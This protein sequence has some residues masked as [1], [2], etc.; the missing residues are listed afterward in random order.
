MFSCMS[1]IALGVASAYAQSGPVLDTSLRRFEVGGQIADI[2]TGCIGLRDC[3]LP[4]FGVGLGAAMNLNEHFALDANV[5]VTPGY[6]TE[7]T[8]F[9]GGRASEFLLGARGEIRAK[10]Y[11]YFLKAQAGVLDW[12]HV[13]DEVVFTSPPIVRLV[14]AN[15]ARFASDVGAGFEYLPGGRIHVRAEVTDLV[16]VS[17]SKL[18]TNNF[19]PSVGVYASLGKPVEWTPPVYDAKTTHPFFDLPNV[20]LITGSALGIAADAVT[21]HHFLDHGI[22]EGDPIARPL[23]K[24][25]WSGQISLSGLEIGAEILGMYGLHRI[26][27]HWIERMIPVGLATA[28]AVFA[29]NN[30][31]IS[32]QREAQATGQ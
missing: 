3:Y 18:V 13:L 2:R 22:Q 19:Q 28:H 6:S 14:F 25:G 16:V 32:D 23:V 26:H 17:G 8:N 10:H 31:K 29:Y 5:N 4:S 24:Y 20:V 27:Q 9:Y 15:R 7:Q 21:T 11:G 12:N 30:T 1:L